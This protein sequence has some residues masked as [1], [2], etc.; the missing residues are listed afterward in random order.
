MHRLPAIR[1]SHFRQRNPSPSYG[2]GLH[3]RLRGLR[4][5]DQRRWAV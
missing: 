3:L 2:R 4:S 1:R 5:F